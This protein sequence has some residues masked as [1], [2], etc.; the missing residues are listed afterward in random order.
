[1][2]SPDQDF[3]IQGTQTHINYLKAFRTYRD[4]I[5]EQWDTPTYHT[6][7]KSFNTSLF[8]S[9]R[10]PASN[11]ICGGDGESE[12]EMEAYRSK[13]KKS[14]NPLPNHSNIENAPGKEPNVDPP[15]PDGSPHISA[16]LLPAPDGINVSLPS[17]VEPGEDHTK[18]RKQPTAKKKVAAA[19]TD[20][21]EVTGR[22]TRG[23]NT[24]RGDKN[25]EQTDDDQRSTR[26][27]KKG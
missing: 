1:M 23:G 5:I 8:G 22:S 4:I 16:P 21:P 9:A 18:P 13:L 7:I 6:I 2:L 11:P 12:E 24:R 25:V 19:A 14:A 27:T 26:C 20:S 3:S 17:G 15:S 10:T